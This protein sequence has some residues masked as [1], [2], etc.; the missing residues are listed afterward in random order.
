MLA[1]SL[2][3]CK[4]MFSSITEIAASC[5][6][7]PEFLALLESEAEAHLQKQKQAGKTLQTIISVLLFRIVD[8]LLTSFLLFS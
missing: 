6:K 4:I 5:N 2:R 8:V 7:W 3:C 1:Y